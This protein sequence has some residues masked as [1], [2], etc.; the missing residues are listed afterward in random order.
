VNKEE[1]MG[2][3]MKHQTPTPN[4]LFLLPPCFTTFFLFDAFHLG[5][6]FL[7]LV[8]VKLWFSV[9]KPT[10][11]NSET[12][13]NMADRS[14]PWQ[15]DGHGEEDPSK[16]FKYKYHPGGDTRKEPKAA[17]SALHSVVVPN[18][19]LPKVSRAA[20]FIPPTS[21]LSFFFQE[22]IYIRLS[23]FSCFFFPL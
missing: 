4:G 20:F 23:L 16:H 3:F 21:P 22:D 15:T 12:T 11:I 14:M 6:S 18:V 7:M 17:P 1:K 5:F 8:F 2:N 10:S 19:T 13:V 9:N